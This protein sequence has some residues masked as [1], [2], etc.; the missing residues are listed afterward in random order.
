MDH[1]ES[2]SKA[3][4]GLTTLMQKLSISQR[5]LIVIV[6]QIARFILFYGRIQEDYAQWAKRK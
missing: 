3:P 6:D 5:L 1:S 4:Q 2:P